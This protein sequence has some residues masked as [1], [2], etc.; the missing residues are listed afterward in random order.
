[1][2]RKI[3]LGCLLAVQ[4][5][6]G[7]AASLDAGA[8]TSV[9]QGGGAFAGA[10]L[11]L[12]LGATPK[13]SAAFAIAPVG[14]SIGSD[15]SVRTRFGEGLAFGI[16]GREAI[17]LKLGGTRVDRLHLAPTRTVRE[18]ASKHGISTAGYIGIGIGVAVIVGGLLFLDAVGD[19]SE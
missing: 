4:A 11:R 12:S 17:T 6:G 16:D 19:A 8:Q 2:M 1:M 10:R 14:R 15:G 9:R 3:V 18:G 13:A 5:A 7:Q